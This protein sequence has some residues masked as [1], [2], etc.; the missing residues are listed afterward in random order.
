M[1][2][3]QGLLGLCAVVVGLMA[4]SIGSA[5]G[6]TL[7]WLILNKVNE[8]TFLKAEITSE[9]D[10]EHITLDGEVGSLKIAITCTG[11]DLVG[12]NLEANGKLTEG[13]KIDLLGCKV[14]EQAPLTKEYKCTVQSPGAAVGL[15][16]SE[17]LKGELVLVGTKLLLRI[18]PKAGP[19]GKFKTIQF[20]GEVCPLPLT[21][22]LHGTLYLE[23]C[24]GF[25]TTHKVKHLLQAEPTNTALYIGGHSAKQLEVTKMLGSF[26]VKLAGAHVGLAWSGMDV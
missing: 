12:A 8:A 24:E 3:K 19:T 4:I 22:V 14:Y 1:H 16:V 23:D 21:N 7:S 11:L 9:K 5:Q 17:E 26:W 25:A 18:E 10:S 6:A 20:E 2:T 15:I 13:F